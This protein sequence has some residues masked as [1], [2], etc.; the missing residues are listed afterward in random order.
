VL[1]DTRLEQG[2]DLRR[3]AARLRIRHPYL[4]AIEEGRYDKLPGA[5]YA[6]GFVRAYADH[7]GLDG[8][9][10]VR[11][12]K[13]EAAGLDQ[14]AELVF[15]E[16]PPERG[17]PGGAI[18]LIALVL[19]I[20]AYGTWYYLSSR[21]AVL[22]DIVAQVPERLANVP[23]ARPSPSAG[24]AGLPTGAPVVSPPAAVGPS[25][26]P[27]VAM[28]PGQTLAGQGRP[29]PGAPTARVA[30][31]AT[32]EPGAAARPDA[33][34]Q[35]PASAARPPDARPPDAR[36]PDARPPD[37]RPPDARPLDAR[38]AQDSGFADRGGTALPAPPP[39]PSATE[40]RAGQPPAALPTMSGS[41]QAFAASQAAPAPPAAE[42]PTGRVFGAGQTDSRVMIKATGDSWVQVRDHDASLLLSRVLKPGDVFHVPDR[43]GI[44]LRTGNA[45]GLEIT[46]DGRPA[47]PVGPAG[48]VRRNVALDPE[49]LL[50]GTATE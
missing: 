22:P 50:A 48:S 43:T 37:A 13:Q 44:V 21:D 30:G 25:G 39:L 29:T 45:G 14:R 7:L 28:A 40:A 41:L 20:S 6:V 42:E 17:V 2:E 33:A 49:R 35:G 26:S 12:F 36:P 32:A 5:P 4:E 15:P 38:P 11:R 10:V 9:E 3:I 27:P 31:V 34:P 47:P 16:P 1:R 23:A 19:G 24:S 18:V 8:A 46:V